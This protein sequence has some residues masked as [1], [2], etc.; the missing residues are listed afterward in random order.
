VLTLDRTAK[1]QR[2]SALRALREGTTFAPEPPP[3]ED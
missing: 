1:D 2:K 3:E